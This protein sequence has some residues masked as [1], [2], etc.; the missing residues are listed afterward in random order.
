MGTV[1][2]L[3]LPRDTCA[4]PLPQ[5]HLTVARVWGAD[6]VYLSRACH[7]GH[8]QEGSPRQQDDAR[9]QAHTRTHTHAL[10]R[11]PV[12]NGARGAHLADVFLSSTGAMMEA[13]PWTDRHETLSALVSS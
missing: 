5:P 13:D 3:A 11:R 6:E 12:T 7:T 8:S 9:T 2:N 1:P 4:L 10:P